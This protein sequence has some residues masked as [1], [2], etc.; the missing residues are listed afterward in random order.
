MAVQELQ[1]LEVFAGRTDV[2]AKGYKKRDSDK[3]RYFLVEE[4]LTADVVAAHFAGEMLVGQYQLLEDSTVRWFALD[5]DEGDTPDEVLAEALSQVER[6]ETAGLH[7]YLERSR[8]GTGYHVWGFFDHPIS[9]AVVR[10]ALKPLVLAA[11]NL[12][13]LY[14]VQTQVLPNKPYG[15]LI[16]LPYF[17]LVADG[18]HELG[19]GVSG[20]CGVFVHPET[21]DALTFEAFLSNLRYNSVDVMQELAESAPAQSHKSARDLPT[22]DAAAVGETNTAGRPDKPLRGVLKLISPYGCRFMHH[23][24]KNRRTLPEPQWYAALQQLTCFEQ[25][26]EAAHMISR[27]YPGYSPDETDAKYDQALRHPPVGCAYIHEHFP[28]LACEGCPMKAPYHKADV[29]LNVLVTESEETLER[30]DYRASVDKAERRMHGEESP[31]VSFGIDDLD[32]YTRLRPNDLVVIGAMPSIGKT[33]F[34]VDVAVRVAE[35]GVPVMFFSAETGRTALETRFMA[36]MSGIDSRAIRGERVVNGRPAPM[37]RAEHGELKAA[38]AHLATLP[39]YLNYTVNDQDKMLS[40]IEQVVLSEGLSYGDPIIVMYDYLQ[41]GSL[42]A[43]EKGL[44]E[45]MQVSMASLAFKQLNK[46]LE[47]TVVILSQ[48]KRDAEGD[49]TPQINWFKNSG[50]VE[51]DADV[52]LILTGERVPG[53]VAKRKITGVKQRD[54]EVGFAVDLLMRQDI[55][56]FEGLPRIGTVQPKETGLFAGDSGAFD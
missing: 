22:W 28:D 7:V 45:Y 53:R 30:S 43:I 29:P 27:D 18:P 4:P 36:R 5:F 34:A 35:Q 51:I 19:G 44:S 56:M 32:Q 20:D 31:G 47:H 17:G 23:A 52:A 54:G 46:V 40:L 50:R 3:V 2:Y 13:R 37:S 41:Y 1:F 15:N 49:D 11:E 48:V 42:Q 14:P 8:S 38:A 55:C 25:G 39:L 12:D 26:R 10:Q 16:A 24:F 21:G 6:F 9:A 33:A